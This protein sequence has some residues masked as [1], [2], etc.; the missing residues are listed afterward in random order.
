MIN[1]NIPTKKLIKTNK[2]SK[3]IKNIINNI[4]ISNYNTQSIIII[5]STIN[6]FKNILT[7]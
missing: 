3:T 4:Y 7:T 5:I 6:N 1:S 2:I